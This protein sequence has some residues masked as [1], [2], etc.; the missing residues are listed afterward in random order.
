M[1]RNVNPIQQVATD[2]GNGA[3]AVDQTSNVAT[4]SDN[5]TVNISST[6]Q[7][8]VLKWTIYCQISHFDFDFSINSGI[9]STFLGIRYV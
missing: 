7:Q 1:D 2:N 3:I 8:D 5:V 9:N 6:L 4:D